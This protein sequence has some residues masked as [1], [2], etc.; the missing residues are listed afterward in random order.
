M[1]DHWQLLRYCA[2]L[3]FTQATT[4]PIEQLEPFMEYAAIRNIGGDAKNL[5][6]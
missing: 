1:L 3:F 2:F 6:P 5:K 4:A